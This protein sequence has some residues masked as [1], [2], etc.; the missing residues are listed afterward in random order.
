MPEKHLFI[1]FWPNITLFGKLFYL[2]FSGTSQR[3][4]LTCTAKKR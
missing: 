2:A 3:G 4:G 1:F